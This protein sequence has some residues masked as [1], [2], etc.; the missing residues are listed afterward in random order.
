MVSL[1]LYTRE[2][3]ND[4]NPFILHLYMTFIPQSYKTFACTN[5]ELIR[6]VEVMVYKTD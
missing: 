6:L 4:S 3:E 2:K 1:T 5:K